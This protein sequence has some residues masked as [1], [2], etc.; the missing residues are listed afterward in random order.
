MRIRLT[1]YFLPAQKPALKPMSRAW[2]SE[3]PVEESGELELEDIN[4]EDNI[5]VPS[6]ET[7]A[8]P[9]SEESQGYIVGTQ[10][11]CYLSDIIADQGL[12][13]AIDDV[14]EIGQAIENDDD[15]ILFNFELVDGDIALFM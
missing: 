10:N 5:A 3:A 15:P 4:G 11:P 8:L 1:M 6:G 13:I 7:E 14:V 2:T 12:N 9:E